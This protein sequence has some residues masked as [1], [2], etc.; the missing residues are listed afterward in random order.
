ML[1]ISR[2]LNSITIAIFDP[3]DLIL[4]DN[5]K[6]LTACEINPII[7]TRSDIL[8]AVE[9]FYGKERAFQDAIDASYKVDELVLGSDDIETQLSLDKLIA[10][11][12]EA[13]VVKLVDLIIQIFNL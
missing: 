11:T 10:K 5:L 1:P 3:L 6:K 9:E 8:Q 13:P 4:I 7:S 2:S 12:E